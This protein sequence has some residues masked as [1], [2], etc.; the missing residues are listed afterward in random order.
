MKRPKTMVTPDGIATVAGI[1]MKL[2]ISKHREET[3]RKIN[4]KSN[5]I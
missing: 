5:L 2:E 4:T 1:G 3:K